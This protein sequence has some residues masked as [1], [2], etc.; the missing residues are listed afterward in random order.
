M[1]PIAPWMVWACIITYISNIFF[2][3]CLC[4][5][6]ERKLFEDRSLVWTLWINGIFGNR[7][8]YIQRNMGIS[9]FHYDYISNNVNKNFYIQICRKKF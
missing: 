9:Y 7:S 3:G 4:F 1:Y 8:N 2:R 5:K 6:I